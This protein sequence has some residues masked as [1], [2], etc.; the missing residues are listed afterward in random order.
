VAAVNER[1][2]YCSLTGFGPQPEGGAMPGFD[3]VAQAA[4]GLMSITGE[5]GGPATKVGVAV[6][7]VLCGLHAAVGILAALAARTRTGRGQLVEANLMLS[8]LSALTNQAGGYLAAGVV[9]ARLGN[10]HPS[11]APYEV[12]PLHDGEIV[13]AVGTDAQ[14]RNLCRVLEIDAVMTDNRF[15][16]NS[17]RVRHRD[18]LRELLTAS[19][20]HLGKA[21]A[22]R[23]FREAGVPAGPV[24][25]MDEAFDFARTLNLDLTWNVDGVPQVRTPFELSGTP[26]R[27]TLGAPA[28]DGMGEDIRQW[29]STPTGDRARS[30]AS[31][32]P[33]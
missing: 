33:G 15:A 32:T 30:P 21:Q 31:Q 7:D 9:P 1:V 26:P 3:L 27:P 13:I 24:N 16:T 25:N 20:G 2:V 6:V 5:A 11:V 19:L 4:S 10:A 17:A 12:F 18:E 29:L 28:L 22:L 23:L 8:A 14:F